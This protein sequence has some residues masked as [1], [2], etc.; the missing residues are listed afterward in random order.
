MWPKGWAL[1]S[2]HCTM[3]HWAAGF[4]MLRACSL[5][6]PSTK[7]ALNLKYRSVA[8]GTGFWSYC[9]TNPSHPL[10]I[11]N[12]LKECQGRWKRVKYSQKY[13][14]Q[15]NTFRSPQIWWLRDLASNK[16][17]ILA[18]QYFP[19]C[20][21]SVEKQHCLPKASFTLE[22]GAGKPAPWERFL[23]YI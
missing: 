12:G 5:R 16:L 6:V 13:N 14:M 10:G 8:S 1:T 7:T 4:Y 17:S 22:R 19:H 23:H 2:I 18:W 11:Q 9:H 15:Y 20:T 21:V 3:Q